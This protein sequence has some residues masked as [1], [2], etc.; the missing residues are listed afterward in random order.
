MISIAVAHEVPEPAEVAFPFDEGF[1]G[2]FIRETDLCGKALV[3]DLSIS[4]ER[5]RCNRPCSAVLVKRLLRSLAGWFG[6]ALC[7]WAEP[8]RS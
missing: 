8:V 2:G 6:R 1:D 3:L 7:L 4:P 5:V